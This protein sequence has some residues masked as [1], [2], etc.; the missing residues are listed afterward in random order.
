MK[1][2]RVLNRR[3]AV[4]RI[5]LVLLWIFIIRKNSDCIVALYIL[6]PYPSLLCQLQTNQFSYQSSITLNGH[7]TIVRQMERLQRK[8]LKRIQSNSHFTDE[9]NDCLRSVNLLPIT[10]QLAF[11]DLLVLNRILTRKLPLEA[12]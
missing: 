4:A 11:L 9:Y 8:S 5:V 12:E 6:K 1:Q 3:A 10:Y 7:K 2:F